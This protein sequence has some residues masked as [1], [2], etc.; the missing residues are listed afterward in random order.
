MAD[1]K[2][3]HTQSACCSLSA[4]QSTSDEL[5]FQDWLGAVKVR[6]GIGRMSYMV[7]PGLW[8]IGNPTKQSPVLVT[9]NYKLT[10]DMLRKELSGLNAWILV[11][12]TKGVNVWC[13]AGKG[14]FGTDELVSKIHSTRIQEHASTQTI[15]VP[16]LGA[17]GIRATEVAEQTGF[18]VV[19]G[20]VRAK[21]LL[22]FLNAGQVA[23][24]TMRQ[25]NFPLIDRLVLV[26]MEL[27]PSLS[28][29]LYVFSI[30]FL[31]NSILGPAF[32]VADAIIVVGT[33]V[34]ATII[35]PMALPILPTKWFSLKGAFCGLAWCALAYTLGLS[36]GMPYVAITGYFLSAV[37]Y[38]AYLLFNFTGSTT[39]TSPSG[40]L[41]E[42]NRGMPA[43]AVS[44]AVGILLVFIG[45]VIG[46]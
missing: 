40:V 34:A 23:T 30:M 18:K 28:H 22:P 26:P 4:P 9:A 32:Q 25:V 10:F 11:L 44:G 7:Q 5:T 15:I 29:L 35:G 27:I 8:T 38:A 46:G 13:A 42:M 21:D 14:T 37:S 31:Y 33:I 17:P 19:F 24:A 6:C 41:K 12:D 1:C 3:T 20:P 43:F 45:K 36:T 2:T 39:F 16:Q